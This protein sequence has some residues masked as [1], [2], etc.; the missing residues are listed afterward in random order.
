MARLGYQY[1]AVAIIEGLILVSRIQ[2][3]TRVD[4]RNVYRVSTVIVRQLVHL[5]SLS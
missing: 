2:R 3:P 4:E 5:I 1:L